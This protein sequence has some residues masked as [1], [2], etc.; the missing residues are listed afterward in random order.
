MKKTEPQV[1]PEESEQALKSALN[2][3]PEPSHIRVSSLQD[4]SKPDEGAAKNESSELNKSQQKKTLAKTNSSRKKLNRNSSM[5]ASK[6]SNKNASELKKNE[7][8]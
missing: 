5:N 8:P 2:D 6:A 3:N 7:L 4:L 1:I